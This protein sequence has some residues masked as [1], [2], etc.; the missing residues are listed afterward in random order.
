MA[1]MQQR[2]APT[3]SHR[4][5]QVERRI[6][7]AFAA[8]KKLTLVGMPERLLATAKSIARLRAAQT[9]RSRPTK[10]H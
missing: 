7:R 8:L 3:V 4:I 2:L 10:Q 1:Q 5:A 9:S 6:A